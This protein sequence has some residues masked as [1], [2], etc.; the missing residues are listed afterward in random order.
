MNPCIGE[1]QLIEIRQLPFLAGDACS[2]FF[3]LVRLKL[4]DASNVSSPLAHTSL[5]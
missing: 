4:G 3:L 2:S 1:S 5:P